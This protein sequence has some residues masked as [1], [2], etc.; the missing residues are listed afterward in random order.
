[1][2]LLRMF[3][4]N[5]RIEILII[6]S[7]KSAADQNTCHGFNLRIEILII[8]SVPGL[9]GGLSNVVCFNLRIEILIIGSF[10]S[11]SSV[12]HNDRVSISE[13]R[14]LSLVGLQQTLYSR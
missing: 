10:P 4:F 13:L 11:S 9:K 8:G 6:G 7:P 2:I 1:M 12:T 5:L 14:F 3:S